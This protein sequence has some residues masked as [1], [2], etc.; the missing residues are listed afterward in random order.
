MKIKKGGEL[1]SEDD[2]VQGKGG[3]RGAGKYEGEEVG[4]EIGRY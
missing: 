2:K 1:R 3:E 4:E